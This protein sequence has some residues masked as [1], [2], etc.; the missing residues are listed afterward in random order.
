LEAGR[1]VRKKVCI[2]APVYFSLGGMGSIVRQLAKVLGERY[3]VILLSIKWIEDERRSFAHYNTALNSTLRMFINPWHV[4]SLFLYELSGM[5]WCFA[6]RLAGAKDFLVQDA[7]FDAFF[8]T[9][10]GKITKARVLL[11]DYGPM[12]FIHDPSFLR[13]SNKFRRGLLHITYTRL[14]RIINR[15]AIR[16]CHKFFV[17]S[18]EMKRFVLAKGLEGQKM[19]IYSFPVDTTIFREYSSGQKEKIRKRLK[20]NEKDVIVTFIGRISKDKGLLYLLEAIKFFTGKYNKRVKFLIAGD[21]PLKEWFVKNIAAYSSSAKFLGAL[22]YSEEVAD[23]LNASDIFV[24][25][26]TVSYGYALSVLEAMASGLPTIFTEV[27]PTKELVSSGYNAFVI[28]IRDSKTLI[29]AIER[30][31]E[32][33]KLRKHIGKNAKEVLEGFSVESYREKVLEHIA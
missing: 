31:I 25:P 33:S 11:F 14:L 18:Q 32:D 3:E 13:E 16:H 10:V 2:V 8:A 28:P 17:Y 19:A 12:M 9:L 7:I 23:V 4:P 1:M 26:I 5:M 20:F 15:F 22:Y 21:G 27:G 24:Y 30:L 29:N 6:L